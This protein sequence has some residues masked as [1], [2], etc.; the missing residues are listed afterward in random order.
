MKT[1]A[2]TI[3]YRLSR[4]L[5]DVQQSLPENVHPEVGKR[6][7]EARS[8]FVC[9]FQQALSTPLEEVP[10]LF[11]AL[12]FHK[13]GFA[14]EGAAMAMVMLDEL[15]GAK[16]EH[17]AALLRGRTEA[18]QVLCAI[19]IGLASARLRKPYSWLPPELG[20][21]YGPLVM[22]GYGFH[23]GFFN[24]YRFGSKVLQGS[25]SKM[26]IHY[27]IGLGRS[28]WFIHFGCVE[29]IVQDISRMPW[30]L[31]IHLW[32]GVGIACAFTGNKEHVSTAMNAATGFENFINT[33]LKKGLKLLDA[34]ANPERNDI[35]IVNNYYRQKSL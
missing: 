20:P 4:L 35:F 31:K 10:S 14:L 1:Y 16:T 21:H 2:N 9:G 5:T 34:L 18:E 28:L 33:G 23:Q 12:P 15:S 27:D 32:Q 26:N 22:D 6:L 17:L 11:Q 3:R 24:R 25:A 7:N 13:L 29:P 19:G 8:A 30:D